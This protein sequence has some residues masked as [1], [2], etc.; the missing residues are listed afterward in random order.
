[1]LA[2]I[3]SIGVGVLDG[4]VLGCTLLITLSFSASMLGLR[5]QA[6]KDPGVALL[7]LFDT[8]WQLLTGLTLLPIL[9]TT[10]GLLLANLMAVTIAGMSSAGAG[11]WL[12]IKLGCALVP[13]SVVTAWILLMVGLVSLGSQGSS[14]EASDDLQQTSS[15]LEQQLETMLNP[16]AEDDS[17]T[18]SDLHTLPGSALSEGSATTS[19]VPLVNPEKVFQLSDAKFLALRYD[20]IQPDDGLDQVLGS[21]RYE[22]NSQRSLQ[23]YPSCADRESV[24]RELERKSDPNGDTTERDRTGNHISLE[25][26]NETSQLETSELPAH[27]LNLPLPVSLCLEER[28]AG[29]T[30]RPASGQVFVTQDSYL[31]K[32]S[33]GVSFL[34]PMVVLD[35]MFALCS[36]DHAKSLSSSTENCLILK[37]P[38][39]EEYSACVIEKT[40]YLSFK[41]GP[42]LVFPGDIL[43]KNSGDP[44]GYTAYPIAD[45]LQDSHILIPTN[46]SSNLG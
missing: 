9:A 21:K 20:I 42:F 25:E 8:C 14:D 38:G 13:A 31:V 2:T 39:T 17:E 35:R 26:P 7:S 37:R 41:S 43:L 15:L 16:Q 45:F 33:K 10:G 24:R 28:C 19:E 23:Q 36:Q 32:S 3:L 46:S 29:T 6:E 30:Y 12:G 34:I 18:P 4:V 22:G 1:M 44:D 5:L 27:S 11:L 40:L